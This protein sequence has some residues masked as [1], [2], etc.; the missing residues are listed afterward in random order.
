MQTGNLILLATTFFPVTFAAVLLPTPGLVIAIIVL[1]GIGG[2]M[3]SCAL[4]EYF[5]NRYKA[6]GFIIIWQAI[7]CIIIDIVEYKLRNFKHANY[8][9]IPLALMSVAMFHWTT[10][11]GYVLNLQTGNLTTASENLYKYLRGFPLGTPKQKG[12]LVA[13]TGA[14]VFFLVGAVCSSLWGYCYQYFSLLPIII[15]SPVHL[16]YVNLLPWTYE[17]QYDG[18]DEQKV[19]TIKRSRQLRASMRWTVLD[20]RSNKGIQ[21]PLLDSQE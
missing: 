9:C 7:C 13:I 2:P 19:A 4:H 16:Y 11:L 20:A 3:L 6:F 18:Y 14:L 12:E 1:A 8:A 21:T 10:K 17:L 15:T 5:R